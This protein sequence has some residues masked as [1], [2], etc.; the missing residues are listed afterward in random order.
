M[1]QGDLVA[2]RRQ[3]LL[4]QII[5]LGLVDPEAHRAVMAAVVVAAVP[6][7]AENVLQTVITMTVWE[8]T[9][10]E[11]VQVPGVAEEVM[12]GRLAVHRSGSSSCQVSHQLSVIIPFTWA[13]AEMAE[14]AGLAV[15][16]AL[17]DRVVPVAFA[18]PVASAITMQEMEES[19]ETAD[20]EVVA[21]VAA[22]AALLA[23]IA[24]IQAV[25]PII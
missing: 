10:A 13:T 24:L 8:V 17:A 18:R 25:Q 7:V 23:F 11:E 9:V 20:M 19:A 15:M 21:A 16:V 12:A 6:V 3:V 4:Y 2:H 22:E 5:G 1:V 14:M